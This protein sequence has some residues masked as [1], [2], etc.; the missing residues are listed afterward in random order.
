MNKAGTKVKENITIGILT[1]HC[2][3][4]YGAVLQ[5]YALRKV[6]SKLDARYDTHIIDYRCKETITATSFKDIKKK[7]GLVG[8]VL[9]YRQINKMNAKFDCFRKNFL[10]LS[11]TYNATEELAADIDEYD[12]LI[13]GSDQVWNLRWSDGD[14]VY[15]QDFHEQN[16]KKY[17]YAASF[18][19]TNLDESRVDFYKET[20][21]KF[22]QIS[23]R[24]KSGKELVEG[25]LGLK[26]IQHIDPTLLLTASEWSEIAKSPDVNGKYILVYMVPKQ[27]SIIEHAMKLKKE[28]GLPIVMLSKNLKPLNVIHRGDSSPEEYVGWFKNAEYVVTNSFHG[29]AFSCIFNKN[30]WIDL[31]TER[32]FNTRS[33]SLIELCG[34]SAYVSKDGVAEIPSEAWKDSKETL[35][36]ERKRA[37]QYL[38]TITDQPAG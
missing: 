5:A 14:T 7:K 22:N 8:A 28:T 17:S 21:K 25:Q 29:T 3:N 23:V 15:F 2:T 33:S 6:L 35:Q 34:L 16:E 10:N 24:E 18:G 27:D 11:K 31:N 38:L 4:N 19:F 37:E 30:I 1:F 26:A 32:G 9:H 12:A 20:L 36:E 13:S